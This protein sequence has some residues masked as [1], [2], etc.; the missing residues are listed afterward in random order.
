MRRHPVDTVALVVGLVLLGGCALWTTWWA[1]WLSSD[2]IEW[3][4][5]VWLVLAG[6]AGAG[7]SLRPGR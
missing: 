7:A 3:V 5:P 1:G 6:I 4:G 2:T